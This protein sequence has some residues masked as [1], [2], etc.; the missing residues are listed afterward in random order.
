MK[1]FFVVTILSVFYAV[2]VVAIAA[3]VTVPILVV[4]VWWFNWWM[5]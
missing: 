2:G 5:S 3:F 4:L 1:E